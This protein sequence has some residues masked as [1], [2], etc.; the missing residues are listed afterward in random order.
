VAVV[1]PSTRRWL[2]KPLD[3]FVKGKVMNREEILNM[4]AGSEMDAL[5]LAKVFGAMAFKGEDGKPYRLDPYQN[6]WS[7]P[8]YSGD[9][10]AA[11]AVV[12]KMHIR[13]W[14]FYCEYTRVQNDSQHWVLFETDECEFDKCAS[15]ETLPLAI[16]RAALLAVAPVDIGGV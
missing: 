4:E 1:F 6:P 13:K 7:V 8:N 3:P 11:W 15:A 2:R 16:C 12:E 9:I 5:V 14:D 10:S